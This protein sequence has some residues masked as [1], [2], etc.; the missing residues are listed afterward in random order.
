MQIIPTNLPKDRESLYYFHSLNI[1]S[2]N[3]D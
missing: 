1:P 2:T 3:K